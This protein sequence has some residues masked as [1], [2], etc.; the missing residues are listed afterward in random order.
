MENISHY[1]V[2]G[3]IPIILTFFAWFIFRFLRP[4]K[5]I[6]WRNTGIFGAFIIALYAEM[7]GF[8]LTLY[9]LSSVFNIDI[10]FAHA[11]GHLW[12][13]L[14]GW[15]TTGAMIEMLIG[16]SIMLIGV[17]LVT[18]GWREIYRAK[19]SLVTYGIYAYIRHPQYTGIILITL[20]MLIHW[21]TLIILLMFPVLVFAY[22]K[23]AKKEE[24]EME[25][26]F[27]KT[28]Q[29]YKSKIPM[30]FPL[31]NFKGRNKSKKIEI[32]K[33]V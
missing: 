10:P 30:F 12:A 22:Y 18:A 19:D 11:E 13:S 32:K 16:Y 20:G 24:K 9:I 3:I 21:P 7:Y 29:E 27:G 28:Y 4:K 5:K 15:G 8:P 33:Y 23:L 6:E 2:W 26:K 31:F 25:I 1:G 17:M 14:F